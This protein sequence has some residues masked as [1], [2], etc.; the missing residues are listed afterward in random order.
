MSWFRSRLYKAVKLFVGVAGVALAVGLGM[1]TGI[2]IDRL[3]HHVTAFVETVAMVVAAALA[4]AAACARLGRG[5][6]RHAILEVDLAHLPPEVADTGVLAQVRGDAKQ[7]SMRETVQALE[8]AAADKR[9]AG[10]FVHVRFTAGGLAQIQE[11]RDAL[12][13]LRTAGKF[14]VAFADTFG[15]L[16]GGNG[17]YYLATGC[18]EI[19]LQPSGEVGLVGLAREVT[20]IR[21]ALDRVGVEP[22]FEGRHEYKSAASQ[23]LGTRFSDPEREQMQRIVDS[24]FGQITAGVAETRGKMSDEVRR[25]ADRAPLLADEARDA[26]L[27]DRVGYRDEA[28]AQ[29]KKRAGNGA[30]LLYLAKYAKRARKSGKGRPATMAVITAT[31]AI[32]PRH[33][34]TNPLIGP[35]QI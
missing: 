22:V 16:G 3:A 7:L 11:L 24:Q 28:L 17:C 5:V 8:R 10:L 9:V 1:G 21:G 32:V 31:G 13:G 29:A 12:I 2:L 4:L 26:G 6:P 27:V 35:S 30:E 18:D 14:T 23:L 33:Q 34:R 19:I 25:L 15:E 20:F